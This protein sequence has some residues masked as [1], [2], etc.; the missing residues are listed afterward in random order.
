MEKIVSNMRS[1][2][3]ELHEDYANRAKAVRGRSTYFAAIATI[4]QCAPAGGRE[5]GMGGGMEGGR[6]GKR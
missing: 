2:L 1:F 5:G 6:G 4:R 3:D